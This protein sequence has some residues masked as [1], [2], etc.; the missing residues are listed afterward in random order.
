MSDM[1]R[2][3]P[4]G[5]RSVLP[6]MALGLV[7]ALSAGCATVEAANEAAS[8]V[9][10]QAPAWFAERRAEVSGRSYPRLADVPQPPTDLRSPAQWQAFD[11]ELTAAGDQ[12]TREVGAI[13]SET[14][15][16][17]FAWTEE[18]KAEVAKGLV[19]DW[20]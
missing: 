13:N 12:L 7:S 9:R 17:P 14:E 15:A 18:A 5:A 1:S 4:R 10:E 3:I 6:I 2:K 11:N 20:E 16:D 8:N 19:E